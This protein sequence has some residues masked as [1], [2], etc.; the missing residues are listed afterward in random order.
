MDPPCCTPGEDDAQVMWGR[1]GDRRR[2][3]T[4]RV[5]RV[6]D[7]RMVMTVQLHRTLPDGAG[8]D[9]VVREVVR[10]DDLSAG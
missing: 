5:D 6:L 3:R 1:A 8:R 9:L 4:R 2:H 7:A 10:H